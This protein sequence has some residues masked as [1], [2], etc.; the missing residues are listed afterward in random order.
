MFFM[1]FTFCA[2][3]FAHPIELIGHQHMNSEQPTPWSSLLK[4]FWGYDELR[5]H[6]I[7]PVKAI[8]AGLDVVAVLP[9]GGG[10]TLCYQL[11]GLVRGGTTLVVSPLIA[12]MQ[13][14]LEDL[15]A[16]GIDAF[17]LGG[18]S[19]QREMERILDNAQRR[20]PCFLFASP[21]K[22]NS[23]RVQVRLTG[24]N[25]RTVAVDEAHCISEWGHDFRPDYRQ[26]AAVRKLIPKAAWG[27]FTATA[28]DKVIHDIRE[29]LELNCPSVFRSSTHRKNLIY[30]VC[31]VRDPEAML[32]QAV[33][34]SEGCG[35][36]YVGTR[37]QAEKWA[38]RLQGLPGGVEAYHAGLSAEVRTQRLQNWLNG[39]VRVVVCTNAFGMGIDKPD[40]RW[41]YHASVPANLE[42]YVQEAGRAGRDGL[43][44]ECVLFTSP[45]MLDDRM[46]QLEQADPGLL[47]INEVYQFLANQGEVA[48]GTKPDQSTPFDSSLFQSKHNVSIRP[49]NRCLQ[50]LQQA[51][52]IGKV[53]SAGEAS[54]Q[55][56]FNGNSQS[57]LQEIGQLSTGES[58]LA[59]CLAPFA[60]QTTIRR[61][62]SDFA[63][64]QI[65]WSRIKFILERMQEWGILTFV[66]QT[67]LRE[68]EWA[69]P[70]V[71]GDIAI[72][73]NLGQV[74]FERSL[75]RLAAFR[76][77][78][79]A[80]TCRQVAIA[81]YFGFHNEAPCD[82]CDNCMLNRAEEVKILNEIP[83]EGINFDALLKQTSPS[84]YSLIIDSLKTAEENGQ[85]R[86]EKRR[87][88]KAD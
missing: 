86:F 46:R 10:K 3:K 63:P 50:L 23:E 45:K 81:D 54:V 71:V 73:Y 70:R 30:A 40:V 35:L 65:D 55:I 51:G 44:S 11:P 47:P 8:C 14:Q 62:Q 36:V 26:L 80:A 41:V 39:D 24:L 18:I 74:P 84:R 34:N 85:I 1:T 82:Q 72:P 78:L 16:K 21:E 7:G 83:I 68:V 17:S 38:L 61:K 27:C 22:L 9:T 37:Y 29:N 19:T 6:Q 32:Y 88:Y 64:L 25:I 15:K 42:S 43:A 48:I 28:T 87:I 53:H 2:H 76:G 52:Y 59:R 58:S 12:L 79:E 60:S 67:G 33:R 57:E 31:E 49:F 4:Q 13:D 5:T 20:Q 66:E 75:K 56:A 69:I 77:F